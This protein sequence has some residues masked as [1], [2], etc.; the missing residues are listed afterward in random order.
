MQKANF[1]I[2]QVRC[3]S[4]ACKIAT[5]FKNELM[6]WGRFYLVLQLLVC[7]SDYRLSAAK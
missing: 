3:Y 5:Y 2:G 6:N 4:N 7:T 1:L